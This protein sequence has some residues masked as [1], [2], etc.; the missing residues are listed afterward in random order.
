MGTG[1]SKQTPLTPEDRAAIEHSRK[2]EKELAK[3]HETDTKT[4]KLLLLGI[5]E[6]KKNFKKCTM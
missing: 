3:S 2:I 4:I 1:A 6:E 5:I